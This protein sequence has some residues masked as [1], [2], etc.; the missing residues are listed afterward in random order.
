MG[1]PATSN[2][3]VLRNGRVIDPLRHVDEIA[4][5]VV[6]DGDPFAFE[7][8]KDRIEQVWKDGVRV[9]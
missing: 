8:L 5:V 7:T 6:V 2:A 1:S 9:V 4:D 3:L